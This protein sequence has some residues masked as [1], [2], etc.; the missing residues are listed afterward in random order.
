M[1]DWEKEARKRSPNPLLT[2]LCVLVF[3]VL[4]VLLVAAVTSRSVF[5][6][7]GQSVGTVVGKAVG[8]AQGVTDGYAD[9]KRKALQADE[10]TVEVAQKLETKQKLEVLRT[11]GDYYDVSKIGENYA[12]LFRMEYT[13]TFSVDM[14]QATVLLEDNTLHITLPQPEIKVVRSGSPEKLDEYQTKS[15]TGSTKDGAAAESNALNELNAKMQEALSQDESLKGAAQEAART[16]VEALVRSLRVYDL[17]IVIDFE[18]A[19]TE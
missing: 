19:V 3:L 4:L 2:W 8:S 11:T 9:G 14:E 13:A 10:I 12:A 1:K 7:I 15:Y 6:S 18:E 17:K 16:Q 5:R